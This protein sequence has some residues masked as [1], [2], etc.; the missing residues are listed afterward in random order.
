MKKLHTNLLY[1]DRFVATRVKFVDFDVHVVKLKS[2]RQVCNPREKELTQPSAE[3]LFLCTL[4]SPVLS[5]FGY[6]KYQ[7][8]HTQYKCKSPLNA[9]TLT[10]LVC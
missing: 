8:K 6:F 3:F 5:V 2:N 9:V 10:S 4:F 7:Y 1:N